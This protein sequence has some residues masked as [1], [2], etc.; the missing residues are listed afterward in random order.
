MSKDSKGLN[1]KL[2][3]L[4]KL[5][6]WFDSADIDLDEAIKKFDAGTKLT[7]DIRDHLKTIDNKITVL[8]ERFDIDA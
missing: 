7:K 6:E 1:Q 5:L 4:D 3:E 8:K 2:E